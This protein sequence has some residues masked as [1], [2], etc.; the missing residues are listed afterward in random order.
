MSSRSSA[1]AA[2]PPKGRI[3]V[4]AALPAASHAA[5]CLIDETR[6]RRGREPRPMRFRFVAQCVSLGRRDGLIQAVRADDT[7][8]ELV[9]TSRTAAHVKEGVPP[10]PEGPRRRVV[11]S[12]I[13]MMRLAARRPDAVPHIPEM[14]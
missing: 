6:G 1:A 10:R 7:P 8:R 11:R 12:T 2:C 4:D 13:A 14:R 3:R 9:L 5:T